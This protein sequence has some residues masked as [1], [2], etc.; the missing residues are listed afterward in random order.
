MPGF[1]NLSLPR[2]P[3]EDTPLA[4]PPGFHPDGLLGGLNLG[5]PGASIDA[6]AN[7]THILS[8]LSIP[9]V[10][11]NVSG[12]NRGPTM[13]F[14]VPVAEI[15]AVRLEDLGPLPPLLPPRIPYSPSPVEKGWNALSDLADKA[16]DAIFHTP[17]ARQGLTAIGAKPAVDLFDTYVRGPVVN[18]LNSPEGDR[19]INDLHYAHESNDAIGDK[20]ELAGGTQA[21]H[22]WANNP[23]LSRS[24]KMSLSKPGFGT[25]G[26]GNTYHAFATGYGVVEDFLRSIRSEKPAPLYNLGADSLKPGLKIPGKR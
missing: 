24:T 14:E 18:Y 4:L 16:N 19:L 15:P 22:T 1:S 6:W 9:S 21:L 10:P 12:T 20:L 5:A 23:H 3:E 8:P 13:E 17:W 2:W 26:I 25:M 11:G 7:G